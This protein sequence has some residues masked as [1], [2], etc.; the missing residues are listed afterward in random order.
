MSMSSLRTAVR[1]FLEGAGPLWA[2]AVTRGHAPLYEESWT[3]M[4]RVGW[5]VAH[6]PVPGGVF[7]LHVFPGRITRPYN[8]PNDCFLAPSASFIKSQRQVVG[9]NVNWLLT[10]LESAQSAM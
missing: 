4:A 7:T 5:E 6:L 1:F 2:R 10:S 9:A 3:L 8:V